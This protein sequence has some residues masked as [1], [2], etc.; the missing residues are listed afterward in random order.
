MDFHEA[1]KEEGKR[2]LGLIEDAVVK[3][4]TVEL[5]QQAHKLKGSALTIGYP[6]VAYVSL[7][8]ESLCQKSE[9]TKASA[10]VPRLQRLMATI[11]QLMVEYFSIRTELDKKESKKDR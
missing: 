8:I 6:E 4:D 7:R 2:I 11:D 10:L 3:H 5:G 9:L 1:F